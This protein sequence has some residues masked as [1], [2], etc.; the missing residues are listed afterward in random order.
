MPQVSVIIPVYNRAGTIGAAVRSVLS[1]THR[2]LELLVVDDGST[3]DSAAIAERF[4]DAR[5]RIIRLERNCGIPQ[6]RNAGLAAARAE[7]VAWLDSDDVARPTRIEEQL[8]YLMAHPDV[9][10]VGA[11]AGKMGIE[12][13]GRLGVRVPP[14][15]H[16]DIVA[17]LLFRSA[18]QNSAITGRT[19][20]LRRYPYGSDFPVC[21]DVDQFQRITADHRTAN[22]PSVLIDRR[23]HK[24]QTIHERVGDM[25]ALKLVLFAK[26]LSRLG[27]QASPDEVARHVQ[28]GYPKMSVVAADAGYLRWAEEWF[29][30][31]RCAN[32]RSGMVDEQAL[33]L[34]SAVFWAR[35]CKEAGHVI[36]WSR[37]G[38]MFLA[39]EPA[40]A[41]GA[42]RGQRWLRSSSWVRARSALAG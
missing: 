32:Q 7:Y 31:L 21:E 14:L 9:A 1:Q 35:A 6:A 4:G 10:F 18:F 29:G 36:G 20:I 15:E 27:L 26:Q 24:G 11:C 38:Q 42:A 19:A 41:L 23:L 3:D 17:W 30:R 8:A 28:L 33:R 5:V 16:E 37:A 2:D 13:R 40:R 34:A 39:G 12:G 25:H 22:L